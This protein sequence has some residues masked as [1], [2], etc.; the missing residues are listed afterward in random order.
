MNQLQDVMSES[1]SDRFPGT[2]S[3]LLHVS[4][5][6]QY[7]PV[8]GEGDQHLNYDSSLYKQQSDLQ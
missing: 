8:R 3:K 6:L 7:L 1:L 2:I 4:H 5:L